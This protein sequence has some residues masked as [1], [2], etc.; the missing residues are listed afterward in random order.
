MY[1]ITL[2]QGQIL[3]A[4]S[5]VRPEGIVYQYNGVQVNESRPYNIK[6]TQVDNN[7]FILVEPEWF[8][9]RTIELI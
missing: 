4:S 7:D 6:L 1:N 3:K 9:Q 8:N 2:K 5:K